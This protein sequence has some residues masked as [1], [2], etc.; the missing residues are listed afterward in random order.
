MNDLV[1]LV[2]TLGVLAVAAERSVEILKISFNLSE[3]IKS[4][5]AKAILYQVLPIAMGAGVY[6]TNTVDLQMITASFSTVTAGLIVGLLTAGGS[7]FWYNIHKLLIGMKVE[8]T[9]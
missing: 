8:K 1:Q 7:S 4:A 2:S 9:G 3:R 5:K 6:W